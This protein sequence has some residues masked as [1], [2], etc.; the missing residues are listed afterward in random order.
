MMGPKCPRESCGHDNRDVANYCAMCGTRILA[1]ARPEPYEK[2]TNAPAW[3]RLT[4]GMSRKDV[5]NLLGEPLATRSGSIEEEW[6]YTS[7][8]S[9]VR[10]WLEFGPDGLLYRWEGPDLE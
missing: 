9:T 10:S 8:R 6:F 4:R 1:A 7:E 5:L 3:T 2:P